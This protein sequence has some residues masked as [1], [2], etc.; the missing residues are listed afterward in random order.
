MV[1]APELDTYAEIVGAQA[2]HE[3]EKA[4]HFDWNIPTAEDVI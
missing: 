4:N 3:Q 1:S 2:I